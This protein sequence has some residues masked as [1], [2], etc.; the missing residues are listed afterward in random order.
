MLYHWVIPQSSSDVLLWSGLFKTGSLSHVP[1]ISLKLTAQMML[2][3]NSL[4]LFLHVLELQACATTP[5]SNVLY[6]SNL[7]CFSFH[8]LVVNW[9]PFKT[10]ISYV[11]VFCLHICLWITRMLCAHTGQ[12]DS[13]KMELQMA[14]SA[15][16]CWEWNPGPVNS[17]QGLKL[18]SFLSSPINW[19]CLRV[20]NWKHQS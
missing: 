7:L 2:A 12:R 3:L 4:Y 8:S 18:L 16:W 14:V 17:S 11:Q 10:T 19:Q 5:D 20:R 9:Q 13:L 1:Q 15:M 6:K